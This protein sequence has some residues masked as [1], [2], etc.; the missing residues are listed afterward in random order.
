ME[1]WALI[2]VRKFLSVL[3]ATEFAGHLARS[4]V[5]DLL[6]AFGNLGDLGELG[7]LA[8]QGDDGGGGRVHTRRGAR[9]ARGFANLAAGARRVEA[10]GRPLKIQRVDAGAHGR[11]STVGQ[12]LLAE[13]G[14]VEGTVAAQKRVAR[15][16]ASPAVRHNVTLCASLPVASSAAQLREIVYRNGHGGASA[17]GGRRGNKG[18]GVDGI[19][20]DGDNVVLG[21]VGVHAG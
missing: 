14:A 20:G 8:T 4:H 6:T 13:T 19:V 12:A 9:G 21:D 10:A 1:D 11:A 3:Q 7:E 18:L 5:D 15:N 17:A 2:N 16:C